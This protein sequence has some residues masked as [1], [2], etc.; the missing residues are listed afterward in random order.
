MNS[1]T[2]SY[3]NHI[4]FGAGRIQELPE[5]CQNLNFTKPLLVI[6]KGLRSFDWVSLI[7]ESLRKARLEVGIFSDISPNPLYSEIQAGVR[8][9]ND[10]TYDGVIAIGGG[11]ALDAGKAMAF[12][13]PQKRPIWDFE[14]IGDQWKTAI[15]D[16]ILPI[17]AIP[18]TAGTGSEVGRASVITNEEA[19]IKKIIFHPQILP[20]IVIADPELTVGLPPH[21][22][23]ATGMDALAHCIE[24]L[25]APGYHPMSEGIAVE[26]IRLIMENLPLAVK[27]GNNIEAR[28]KML[29]SASM[30]AVAFQKGLGAVHALSH[31]LGAIYH[32]HHGLTNAVLLP[33]VLKFNQSA[34][35]Q[36]ITRISRFMD[37][38]QPNFDGFMQW[39]LDLRRSIDIPHTL[40]D[41]GVDDQQ[42]DLICE[43]A[44]EDPSAKGNPIKLTHANLKQIFNASMAGEL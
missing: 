21:L 26:G 11:S 39:L 23:A 29:I 35:E 44:L 42:V 43:M 36:R 18:T 28:G 32:T 40:T 16:G 4:R 9:L 33:Y 10:E 19:K 27:E 6:D 2:W 3:P 25:C 17:I 30:G 12:M 37:L 41:I 8:V 13:K 20:S 15:T 1:A 24:A 38:A 14:D 22:T 31:P 34:I 5:A 7:V